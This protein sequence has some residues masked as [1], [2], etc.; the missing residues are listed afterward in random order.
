M[1]LCAILFAMGC[2]KYPVNPP[3]RHVNM[4]EGYRYNNLKDSG[5]QDEAKEN[6]VILTF[7]GGGT[8]AAALSYGVLAHL[9]EARIRRDRDTLLDEVDVISSVSA[10]SFTAAYYGLFGK[11]RFFRQFKK[12]VLYRKIERD[13]LLSALAPWNWIKLAS[14]YF[15][16]SDLA[17]RY[18]DRNIFE[19]RT[20]ADM[21]RRRPFIIINATDIT[22]GAQFSFV[23]EDFDRLCS[24]LSGVHVSRAVTAS[25]AFPGVFTPLTFKNYPKSECG[26]TA[27]EW[28]A[29]SLRHFDTGLSRYDRAKTWVS[30]E[31]AERR[32]FIHLIDG[33]MADDIGLRGPEVAITT[34]DSSWSVLRM[35][36]KGL[37][38]RLVIIVVD[39]KPAKDLVLDRSARPPGLLAVLQAAG[40]N[41][42]ENYSA[43]T[44]EMLRERFS[45]WNKAANDFDLRRRRC[46]QFAANLCAK[47]SSG[48]EC[49][50]RLREECYSEFG[51]TESDQPPHPALY[52]IHIRLE[53]IKDKSLRKRLAAE[54]TT[55][56]LPREDVDLLINAGA[57]LLDQSQVYQKLLVD[58]QDPGAITGTVGSLGRR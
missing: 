35:V 45:E 11:A 21:P 39:G 24:D 29:Q 42:M 51:A 16:R 58:L 46:E 40:K 12:D 20:F 43:D 9:N 13:L 4:S 22:L 8:R 52:E 56:Q 6:F 2:A 48:T 7:S 32:P 30:Y 27:P 57:T 10:G 49:E 17:D 34:T 31:D 26:Y 54:P 18:Y 3:L 28:V 44:I 41:P 23:Q 19:G 5:S 38:K 25:S 1:A 14:P 53:A 33:G 15:G 47:S 36:D 55:L 50:S 37:I